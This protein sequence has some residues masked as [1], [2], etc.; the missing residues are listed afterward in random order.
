MAVTDIRFTTGSG[1]TS[2]PTEFVGYNV[3]R[4]GEKLN[5]E[6]LTETQ[7]QIPAQQ[8]VTGEY[9]VKAVYNNAESA[10]TEPVMIQVSGLNG[11]AVAGKLLTVEGTT[12]VISGTGAY[13]VADVA[14]RTLAAGEGAARVA[15]VPGTYVVAVDG[16][17][18][19]VA[20]K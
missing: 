15:V 3:Y 5:D 17:V 14:G 16:E 2:D 20:V 10:A 7:Y 12:L 18:F 19:K 13:T 6:P 8:L 1:M 4:D 11:A 9:S